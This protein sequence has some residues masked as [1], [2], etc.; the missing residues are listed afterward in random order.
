MFIIFPLGNILKKLEQKT[1]AQK[2]MLKEKTHLHDAWQNFLQDL[3]KIVPQNE[4]E[5]WVQNLELVEVEEDCVVFSG[6]SSFFTDY[7]KERYQKQFRELLQSHLAPMQNLKSNFG[8]S[9]VLSPHQNLPTPTKI[10]KTSEGRAMKLN[11]HHRFE[12]F[13][14]G[15]NTDIAFA[16]ALAV[17]ENISRPKYNPLFICGSVGLGK[18]HLMQAIGVRVFEKQPHLKIHYTSAEGFT[19]DVIEG[20]RFSKTHEMR[21]KY[22]NLDLLLI[23][24]IQFLEN[25]ISTQ[26]EF[27]HTLNELFQNNKQIVVTAD[28]YPREIKNIE[29]RLIS[30]FSAGMV[31]KIE[32]PDFETRY[33]IVKNEIEH[34]D[35]KVPEEVIEH[36]AYSVKTNVRDII[37]VLTKLEAES[38]LLGLDLT[39]ES[40]RL[41]LKEILGLDK[42]PKSVEEVIKLVANELDVKKADILSEKRDRDI[43][44]ARQIAMYA[45]REVTSLSYPVIGRYFEKNHTTVIQA[46][47][48]IKIWIEEDPETRQL[49]NSL[50]KK[51]EMN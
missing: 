7:V 4:V 18:T 33:A 30:R 14:N 35:L 47:K 11:F 46:C 49:V 43:S 12:R 9:F 15:A 50:I 8:I 23:D 2:P 28:R 45:A 19:N 22:R 26:E 29:E 42:S 17:T 20:I 10:P 16:A 48:K 36:I 39:L 5:A 3:N 37:G 51:I 1:V 13:I 32:S 31:A 25:K 40:A 41:I 6:L 21:K 24:D 34:K 38:S 27:F 44:N